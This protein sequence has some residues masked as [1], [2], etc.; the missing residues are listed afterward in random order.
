MQVPQIG[1]SRISLYYREMLIK[2]KVTY[3]NC[4][5][6]VTYLNSLHKLYHGQSGLKIDLIAMNGTCVCKHSQCLKM[7]RKLIVAVSED[8]KTELGH[9]AQSIGHLT[10]KSEV[11]VWIPGLA[12]YFRFS[13]R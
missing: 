7:G 9:V 1:R 13:F 11:L 6:L 2:G 8:E 12:T 5:S 3:Q 4:V 10:C